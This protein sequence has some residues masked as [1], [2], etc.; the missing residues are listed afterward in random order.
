MTLPAPDRIIAAA[1]TIDPVFTNSPVLRDTGLDARF[2][3]S[4]ALKVE[5]LNPI[6]SFKGRGTDFLFQ[7]FGAEKPHTVIA[8]SAGNFGQG[9]A[10]AARK[11]GAKCIIYVAGDA[12]PLKVAAMRRF[13]AE[14]RVAGDDLDSAKSTARQDA[15]ALGGLF[16]EDGEIAAISEGAGTI[17]HELHRDGQLGD[18]MLIPL[19]NGALSTGIGTYV[20]SVRPET[21][22][23]AVAAAGAPSMALSFAQER[24]V[25]TESV[26][27][28]ADGI[29]VR[30]PVPIALDAMKGTIDEVVTVPDDMIVQA[31]R[32]CFYDLSLVVEPAGAAGLAALV[33]D[34][35]R[36]KGA[37]LSTVLCGGNVT[38]DQ[39][40]N[41][42]LVDQ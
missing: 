24:Y 16:V 42:F 39:A 22:I 11:H 1:G 23:I 7:T 9:L 35:A 34:P 8:A 2:S 41:W 5:T 31:M 12:N 29:A 21:K 38:P 26:N 14:I 6:R 27:T 28:I 19:G 18:I 17:A 4:L 13:G 40:R 20:K 25:E 32:L 3:A 36:F 15:N 10:V 37:Q 30:Q 33:A